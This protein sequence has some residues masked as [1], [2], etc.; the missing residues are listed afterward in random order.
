MTE[1]KQLART[2]AFRVSADEYELLEYLRQRDNLKNVS[3]LIRK[4]LAGDLQNAQMS[5]LM[6]DKRT[7]RAN[8]KKAAQP[9]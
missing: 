2:I 5:K 7:A 1:K 4:L 9:Q 3:A 6:A 8:A